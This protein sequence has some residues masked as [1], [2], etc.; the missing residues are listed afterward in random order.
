MTQS[1]WYRVGKMYV[2][3]LKQSGDA[4][5][6]QVVEAQLDKTVTAVAK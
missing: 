4:A 3:K 6:A 1:N 5:K 2:E